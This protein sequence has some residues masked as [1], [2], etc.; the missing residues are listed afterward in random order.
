VASDSSIVEITEAANGGYEILHE[1]RSEG[2]V[3]RFFVTFRHVLGLIFGYTYTFIQQQ[4]QQGKGWSVGVLLLRIPLLIAWPFLNRK[5]IKQPFPVQFRRRLEMLGP[6]YIKLGQILSLREDLLPKPITDELKNLLDRLPAVSFSRYIELLEES[7]KRPVGSMFPLIDPVPLGSASLAQTH[8]ARLVTGEDVVLKV[9]KPN[10][11]QMVINDT[12]WMRLVGRFAQLFV[13]RYQPRRLISEFSRYTVLEV[14]LR[15]EADNAEIFTANFVDEPD[16][17]FPQIYRE[18]SSRDVLCMEFFRGHKPDADLVSWMP[19]EQ[20]DNVVALGMRATIEMIFR[21][22]FFHAD[23]HPGNLVVFDDASV[24]FIDLGM[25][26]RFDSDMQKRMLSYLY[27]LVMGEPASAARYLVAL[28]I[29]DRKSDPDG[30][31][32]AVEDLNRRWLRNPNFDEFSM[33]QL[34]LQ[35]VALAGHYRIQY[36]GEIILMVKALITLEGVG[37]VLA[38]GINVADAARKDVQRILLKQLNLVKFFKDSLLVLPDVLDILN[39]SPLVIS[40]G[41]QFLEY[42]LKSPSEGA[43]YGL[44]GT[45]FASFC[46]IAGAVVV[47]TDGPALLWG[48]LF[49]SAFSIA[50]FG[51]ISRR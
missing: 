18:F 15:N 25:V 12:R 37:N 6:T 4:K 27:S 1:R 36:P 49:F 5:L 48:F 47:A 13:A 8:R 29:A 16:I 11:R 43:L 31:R 3:P 38:P 2:L 21:D 10:V 50:G 20:L 7:L 22:G 51:M 23:L 9:L 40:E 26:G 45:L 30:F 33:A 17:K 14:D 34:I 24:G 41:L 35:S 19:T 32:R 28:L 42:Q 46:L 39:R 44:R